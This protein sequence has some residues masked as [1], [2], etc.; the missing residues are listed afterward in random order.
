METASAGWAAA[1]L[2][3]VA[4]YFQTAA[5]REVDRRVVLAGLPPAQMVA[6]RLL[7][8]AALALFAAAVALVAL[9]ARTGFDDPAR[10]VA[11]TV[12]F[13][14]I[15]LAIGAV[16]GTLVRNP[17]NGT[18]IVLFVWIL[19]VF[20]G[21]AMSAADRWATRPFPTHFVT[22]WM[23][24][25]PSGHGGRLGDLGWALAW[26]I[27][28]VAL[29]WLVAIARTRRSRTRRAARP[30]GVHAQ[31]L[32]ASAA[33]WRDAG[34][35]PALWVLFA[36]VPVV[37]IWTADA[38][39]PN[40]PIALTISEAGEHLPAVYSMPEV[41][42][43]TMAPIA[44]ASLAAL[45]GLFAMA[46]ARD[47]DRRAALAGMRTGALLTARLGV[48]AA[49]ALAATAIS[50]AATAVVFDAVRWP[51]YIGANILLALTYALVGALL[52]PVFGR[53]G[54]VFLAF[55]LPFLD[56]GISQSPMLR[57]EPAA[58][59]QLLPGY[60]CSRVLLDGALTSS[61]NETRPLFYGLAW[62]A[63]LAVLVAVA[64]RRAIAPVPGAI[65]DFSAASRTGSRVS[66]SS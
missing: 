24:D 15:Y 33:A 22:L 18:I 49:A 4:M 32:A 17:V 46:D 40:Q 47:G 16:I 9:A 25:L 53:V 59:A 44:I 45:V 29:A 55:L 7:T 13:A 54:G 20:F 38:V 52:A 23:V 21:P 57:P 64:Y 56:I 12:M 58:A 5:T 31:V 50:L 36:V 28:A 62:L 11:G 42:G 26:T 10:I 37:F 8:G 63:A 3:G 48:L 27:G 14:L 19:D 41:H 43:A 65:A 1:F 6:A 66:P 61:F 51:V 60:G 34:R 2:A 39:T 35:N 30:G